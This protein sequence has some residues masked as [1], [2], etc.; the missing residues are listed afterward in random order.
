M[1]S[2]R[3]PAPPRSSAG[4]GGF[5]AG[6]H[7]E[8][9]FGLGRV[10]DRARRHLLGQHVAEAGDLLEAEQLCTDG[11]RMSASIRS[12]LRPAAAA[13]RAIARAVVD[14]PSPARLLV[15][16]IVFGAPFSD[17]SSTEARTV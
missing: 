12:T 3:K 13:S 5:G 1:S 6:R 8:Q 11:R 9:I 10:D 4:L 15:I 14:F 2:A 7:G 16:A 17:D